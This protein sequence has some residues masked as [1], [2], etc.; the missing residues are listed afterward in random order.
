MENFIPKEKMS[1]KARKALNRKKRQTWGS[2]NPTTRKPENPKA[3][4]RKKV[5]PGEDDFPPVEPFAFIKASP[6]RFL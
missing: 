6:I 3:Y 1:K 5:Q 2:L 4:K